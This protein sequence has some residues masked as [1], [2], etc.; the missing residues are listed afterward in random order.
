MDTTGP[1]GP[2][3]LIPVCS[4]RKLQSFRSSWLQGLPPCF[5]SL[6]ELLGLDLR[7][8]LLTGLPEELGNLSKLVEF[9]AFEQSHE[10]FEED[11]CPGDS[12]CKPSYQSIIDP[13]GSGK[14]R[15]TSSSQSWSQDL[16]LMPIF[17]WHNLEKFWVDANALQASPGFLQKAAMAW[18]NLR[19]LDLYDND[20]SLDV[21]ELSAFA[22]HPLLHQ[23]QLQRNNLHGVLPD[24]ILNSS[25]LVTLFLSLNPRVQGCISS[26]RAKRIAVMR[27]DTGIRLADSCEDA[28]RSE[29]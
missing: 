23:V 14:Y 29:L 17:K 6:T 13:D 3:E 7:N 20:L 2:E 24:A 1:T 15:C 16:S 22:H 8:G 26:E 18:P 28:V 25:S 4:L 5:G 19:T 9:I 12:S 21:G 10:E 11:S 27:A